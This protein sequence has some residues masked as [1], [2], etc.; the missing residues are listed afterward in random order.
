MRNFQDVTVVEVAARMDRSIAAVA[1]LLFGGD[2]PVA[3]LEY[4]SLTR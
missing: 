1:R 3:R 4:D 2:G